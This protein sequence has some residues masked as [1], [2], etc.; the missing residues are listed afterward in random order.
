MVVIYRHAKLH[1][2]NFLDS[3]KGA[4][5]PN[6]GIRDGHISTLLCQLGNIAHRVKRHLE[7]DARTGHILGDPEASRYWSRTYEKGWE[8]AL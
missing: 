7:I 4:A 8:M 6:A 2:R 1:V 3:V 5:R